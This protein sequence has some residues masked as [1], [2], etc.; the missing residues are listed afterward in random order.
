MI[1]RGTLKNL[2]VLFY[3]INGECELKFDDF[4]GTIKKNSL[5]LVRPQ[6]LFQ[7]TFKK[8][9][10]YEYLVIDIQPTV[11]KKQIGDKNF[12][13][14]FDVFGKKNE[15]TTIIAPTNNKRINLPTKDAACALFCFLS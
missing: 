9:K 8:D 13:R 12:A 14:A 10:Q 11:L 2:Y 5:V 3:V 7:Y 15:T 4:K 1:Y 6:Q